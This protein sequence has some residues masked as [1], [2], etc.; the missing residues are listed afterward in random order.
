MRQGFTEGRLEHTLLIMM[1][2]ANIAKLRRL[3]SL[4][5]EICSGAVY[6]CEGRP[7][8]LSILEAA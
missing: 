2:N 1:A 3:P 5:A 8:V 6:Y 4:L 7:E